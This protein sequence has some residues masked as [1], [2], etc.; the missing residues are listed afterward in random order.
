MAA[1]EPRIAGVSGP[2]K[3]AQQN[4][5]II[6]NEPTNSAMQMF[7]TTLV[8]SVSIRMRNGVI[9]NMS[10]SC[11]IIKVATSQSSSGVAVPLAA[12]WLASVVAGNPTAPKP[13][14]T[15][16]AIKQITAENMGLKPKPIRMAA[17]MATAVPKPA[18]PSSTP[19]RPHVSSS[20]SRPLSEVIWINCVLIVSISLVSQRML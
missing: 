19:P 15:V 7:L 11:R 12:T 9:K 5:T 13:T 4:C 14:A 20:T 1:T 16:L 8:L 17:G 18:I 6:E 10:D 2:I 3:W